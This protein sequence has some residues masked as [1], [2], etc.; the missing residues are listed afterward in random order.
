MQNAPTRSYRC[1]YHPKDKFGYVVLSDTGALPSIRLQAENANQAEML[2]W[3]TVGCP[4][5]SVERLDEQE[6]M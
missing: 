5:A 4:I 6:V 1:S 2:A 3:A